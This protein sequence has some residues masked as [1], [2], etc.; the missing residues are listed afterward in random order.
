MSIPVENDFCFPAIY[1]IKRKRDF[2]KIFAEGVVASDQVLVIHALRN[3]LLI[4]ESVCRSPNALVLLLFAIN[5]NVG[6]E[7]R[8]D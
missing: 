5:G 4:P 7:K 3:D 8:F 1:R 6:C 2:D